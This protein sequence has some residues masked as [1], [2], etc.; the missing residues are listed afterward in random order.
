MLSRAMAQ[1]IEH[2]LL[3]RLKPNRRNPRRHSDG[4]I[5]AIAGSIL[6]FGFNSPIGID[7][8]GNIIT[9]FGR[10]LA[11]IQLKLETVPVIVLDHLTETE[12]RA[13]LIAHNKL[14]ELSSF[15]DDLLREELAE[16]RDTDID[17]GALGFS[18]DELAVLLANADD[19]SEAGEDAEEEIPEAPAEP[20]TRAGDIWT[21]AGHKIVCGDWRDRDVVHRL[22]DGAKANLVITSPPYA[23]QREYDPE[24][25]FTPVPPEAYCD[26]FRVVAANIAA[27]LAPDGSYFLNIKAH[28]D[29]GERNLYVMDL[30]LAHKRQW[31]WRFVDEF[32]WRKTDNGVPGGWNNRFKNAFEPVY[33]FCRQPQIKLRPTAVGH[34]SEDCFDY[35]PNNPKSNSGSGLLGTGARGAAAGKPG[36]HDSDGR[37][38]GIARPSNVI[39]VKSESSQGSHSAPF[40]RA[41]VEFFVKAFSDPGDVVY[42]CFLGSA[43]TIAAAAV[44]GRVGCGVE[45]SPTYTDVAVRRIANL[46]S[47]EPILTETGQT[48]TEV[49]AARG[50][51]VE[52]AVNP[53]QKDA[54]RIRL[55]GPAPFYTGRNGRRVET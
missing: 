30:V 45:I 23:T 20:V 16:L 6:A 41:L 25:G 46:I 21:I 43:S 49:A 28:A 9:G 37:F 40:P 29:D 47:E 33:H 50:V 14:A 1:R 19:G 11:S 22:F 8:Q 38:A 32:C 12:K 4:Q 31:G 48:M 53:K 5:A 26:W 44:L 36:A 15:A 3:S 7:S 55:N 10:Y 34:V 24:S 27:V 35:S 13:Y 42:D 18:D 52:Q 2:W 39:E 17:R 54:R 51:P